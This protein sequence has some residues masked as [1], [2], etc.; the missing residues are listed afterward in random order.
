MTHTRK[1]K[2]ECGGP[3]FGKLTPGCKQ[4]D[5]LINH[6][7]EPVSWGTSRISAQ[8]NS[9]NPVPFH[10][11]NSRIAQNPEFA[12]WTFAELCERITGSEGILKKEGD[13][14]FMIDREELE[15]L[16]AMRRERTARWINELS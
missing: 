16:A 9:T 2:H 3:V 6:E 4:C 7:R 10:K 15:E 14:C 13:R 5:E 8:Y 12:D 1:S 11:L